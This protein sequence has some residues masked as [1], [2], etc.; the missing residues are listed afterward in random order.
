MTKSLIDIS[1]DESHPEGGHAIILVRSV[2]TMPEPLNFTISALPEGPGS[3]PKWSLGTRSPSTARLTPEGLVLHVGPGIVDAPELKPGTPVV[4]TIPPGRIH[5]EFRWPDLAAG[6]TGSSRSPTEDS[7]DLCA[8]IMANVTARSD[9][10]RNGVTSW[11]GLASPQ[12]DAAAGA[13]RPPRAG[14]LA[15]SLAAMA[16]AT[17]VDADQG[18]TLSLEPGAFNLAVD[19][20]A[21]PIKPSIRLADLA[22]AEHNQ[23][24]MPVD[25]APLAA[26]EITAP[27]MRVDVFRRHGLSIV[28]ALIALPALAFAFWPSLTPPV[29]QPAL[30]VA[31]A[32]PLAASDWMTRILAVGDRSPG[33]VDASNVSAEDALRHAEASIFKTGDKA[34]PEERRFWLRKSIALLLAK[35]DSRW[36]ITQLGALHTASADA[37]NQQP[38]YRTAKTLWE[39]ASA[40][41]DT[42]AT[43]FLAHIYELGLGVKAD[44]DKAAAWYRRADA[45][46]GCNIKHERL[47]PAL[48]N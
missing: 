1:A 45:R 18:A 38:D 27:P 21:T 5:A 36:A 25:E 13:G 8:R 10:G 33:G 31:T 7:Q 43:C 24:L 42:V 22:A 23:P 26:S 48:T 37:T 11:P 6:H 28:L 15:D 4:L 44:R 40:S 41:G 47:A 34:D 20:P 17:P 46:G 2:D 29:A 12:P 3:E 30:T 39:I 32:A 35:P 9:D 14:N 19:P 16:Q